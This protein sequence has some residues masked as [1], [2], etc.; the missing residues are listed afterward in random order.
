[1]K[2]KI[3]PS[4]DAETVVWESPL[5]YSMSY[6]PAVFTLD[7]TGEADILCHASRGR[8]AACGDGKLCRCAGKCGLEV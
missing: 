7:D 3:N 1:M 5:G 2:K 4:E 6:D 8:F